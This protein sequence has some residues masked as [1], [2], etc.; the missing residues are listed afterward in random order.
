MSMKKSNNIINYLIIALTLLSCLLSIFNNNIYQDGE[1]ANAQWLGQD[2]I[3]LLLALPLLLLSTI[4]RKQSDD[5]KWLM[6]NTAILLYYVYTYSFFMFA[7]KLTILY[8]FHL[9]IFGLAVFGFVS[10][11]IFIFIKNIDYNFRSKGL[12]ISIIIYLVLISLM[13]SFIWFSDIFAHLTNPDYRSDTPNG[14]APLI[15]YSLDLAI[16]IPLML[17][18]VILFVKNR[19]SGFIWT[20]IILTKTSTL[21]FALMAMALSMYVQDLNPDTFLIVLWSVLGLIGTYLTLQ[22]FRS[23]EAVTISKEELRK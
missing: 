17:L 1:W 21:G 23:L 2:I 13:I 15:I 11:V 14:E 22:Y 8:L 5:I 9:P 18:S 19:K 16:I 12:K 10:N 3:T 20:G 4:K 7:A 6:I